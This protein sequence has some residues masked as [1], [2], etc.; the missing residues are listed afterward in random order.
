MTTRQ[1]VEGGD[2]L[3]SITTDRTAHRRFHEP[4]RSPN[5]LPRRKLPDA[6]SDRDGELP[7]F[8]DAQ[9]RVVRAERID[10]LI[11]AR[12]CLGGPDRRRDSRI[13]R[14]PGEPFH[15][16]ESDRRRRQGRIHGR[17]VRHRDGVR[18]GC[19]RLVGHRDARSTEELGRI[20]ALASGVG[21]GLDEA[22]VAPPETE[23]EYDTEQETNHGCCA[24]LRRCDDAAHPVPGIDAPRTRPGRSVRHPSRPR[25]GTAPGIAQVTGGIVAARLPGVSPRG[26]ST[27]RNVYAPRPEGPNG[28]RRIGV[29]EPRC[30]ERDGSWLNL[31]TPGGDPQPEDWTPGGQMPPGVA[32]FR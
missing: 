19:G 16:S 24:R 6:P 22:L 2:R 10:R 7:A 30:A 18:H 29:P 31:E 28:G 4:S 5:R 11:E 9:E 8:P 17:R 13:P 15:R 14:C 1:L 23:R 21:R 20:E 3:G 25:S 27:P 12:G 32:S 26:G